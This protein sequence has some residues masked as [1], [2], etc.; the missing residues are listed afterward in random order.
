MLLSLQLVRQA[1]CLV[2]EHLQV[3]VYL[4]IDDPRIRSLLNA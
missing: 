4:G 2:V 1:H 3:L